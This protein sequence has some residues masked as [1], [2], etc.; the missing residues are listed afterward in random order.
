M[1][2]RFASTL[3]PEA[4]APALAHSPTDQQ[5]DIFNWFTAGSGNLVVRARAGTGKTWTLCHAIETAPE[6]NIFVTS[7]GNRIVRELTERLGDNTNVLVKSLH[8]VGLQ[9]IRRV[10]PRV[11]VDENNVRAKGLTDAVCPPNVYDS[12]RRP[13]TKLHTKARE[14]M[15]HATSADELVKPALLWECVPPGAQ[16]EDIAKY[17]YLAMMKA[18]DDTTLIDFADMI[19]LPIRKGYARAR[20]DLV[21]VDEAQD[22]SEPQLEI[23]QCL[24]NP[25]GRMALFGD[26][27]QAIFA[28]RGADSN[29]LDRLKAELDATELPLTTTFRCGS[30][31]VDEARRIVPDIEARPD[32]HD[33]AVTTMTVGGMQANVQSGDFI[34]S[35][36]N[37]PLVKIALGLLR[38][39][40]RTKIEGR[41]IGKTLVALTK[42]FGR[43]GDVQ[44]IVT[45]YDNLEEWEKRQVMMAERAD[46]PQRADMV[47]DQA[48]CLRAIAED[49]TTVQQI[50]DRIVEL[51]DDTLGRGDFIVCSSVHRAKGLEADRVFVLRDTLYLRVA[52][53]CGHR[54]SKGQPAC[55]RCACTNYAP[56]PLAQREEE[57]I[58]YVAIT[59]SKHQLTW[60]VGR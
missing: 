57:N 30:L 10:L 56:D 11:R 23:A 34:L 58:A 33:G 1:G 44:D 39:R 59:R 24:L 32:A 48:D 18:L 4:A 29:A 13:I 54:H 14:S 47:R 28:F 55:A 45:W 40:R 46:V 49:C 5:F 15:P 37:A 52:C 17:A 9:A 22:V 6:T 8:G 19:Y 21:V 27:R 35:R 31:I 2:L 38:N 26:D 53:V 50:E 20:F 3:E 43:Y 60:V 51:F 7:Y 16:P 41:D 42:R 12:V 25:G 36:T